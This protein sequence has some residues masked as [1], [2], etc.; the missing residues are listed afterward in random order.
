[1]P[2][3]KS[4]KNRIKPVPLG[5]SLLLGFETPGERRR[6]A[7][8][9]RRRFPDDAEAIVAE[10]ERLIREPIPQR[11][12]TLFNRYRVDG[13]RSAYQKPYWDIHMRALPALRLGAL[14]TDRD[15]ILARLQDYLWEICNYD[16]WAL[17]A[18]VPP[19]LDPE[20]PVVDLFAAVT[21]EHIGETLDLLSDRLAPE[22]V[23]RCRHEVRA[24]VLDPMIEHPNQFW[25]ASRISNNWSAVCF[26]AVGC[27]AALTRLERKDLIPLLETCRAGME[28]YLD[29][30]GPDDGVAEGVSY[31]RFAMVHAARFA[32]VLEK[33]TDGKV[34]LFE[35]KA[36]RR[37]GRF[38][39]MLFL[40][41]DAYVNFSDCTS[42][43]IGREL[44]YLLMRNSECAR[45]LAWLAEQ[46]VERGASPLAEAQSVRAW[47]PPRVRVRPRPPQE[48]VAVFR[49]L[50]WVVLRE[51]WDDPD[52]AV[53][54]ARAGHNGESHNQLDV[55]HYIFHVFGETFVRDLGRGEYTRQYFGATRYDN[56]FCNAEGHNSIFIDGVAQTPGEERRG[57]LGKV[58]SSDAGDRVKIDLTALYPEGLVERVSREFE[59]IR[60]T[61]PCSLRVV[62]VVRRQ[63]RGPVET[64]IHV[65]VPLETDARG[66]WLNGRRGRVRLEVSGDDVRVERGCL[67]GLQ[68][69]TE[70]AEF[71]RLF[72]SSQSDET[73]IEYRFTPE[74][75]A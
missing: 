74:A 42:A 75:R 43:P 19:Q 50:D 5:R 47:R 69:D 30:L 65:G 59:F 45:E 24:R 17:P 57:K 34:S 49:E 62:D 73:R 54:A 51:T 25:W 2:K 56:V 44:L 37:A 68:G 8:A 23:A 53:F 72:A 27:A 21:A 26:G 4:L 36:F 52:A 10:C 39:L 33:I 13:N 3:R 48:T 11:P 60:S 67:E 71:V 38:P 63:A 14:L 18:H 6:V 40:P 55:G 64:R 22:I 20:L 29:L 31:W 41:P 7:A 16:P 12:Y 66:A 58:K 32:D 35:R 1:M 70:R 9:T 46:P 15:D 28:K 61:T